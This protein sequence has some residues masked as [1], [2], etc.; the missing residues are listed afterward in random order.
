MIEKLKPQQTK[1]IVQVL[2]AIFAIFLLYALR[3]FMDA[4]LGAVIIYVLFRPL[5]R[6]LTEKKKWKR[7]LSAMLIIVLTLFIIIIPVWMIVS[8]VIPKLMAI[9]SDSTMI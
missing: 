6:Y 4:F 5:M 9:L 1:L 3:V 8:Y 2:I 7:W